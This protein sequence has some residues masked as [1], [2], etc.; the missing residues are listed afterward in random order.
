MHQHDASVLVLLS[1]R[2][3]WWFKHETPKDTSLLDPVL[4]H[5][6]LSTAATDGLE[7]G[8]HS[9]VQE[10]GDVMYVPR[11]WYHGTSNEDDDEITVGIAWQEAIGT[12]SKAAKK[13]RKRVRKLLK[14]K[15]G[16]VTGT[17]W[18][19]LYDARLFLDELQEK[20]KLHR[21]ILETRKGKRLFETAER[22]AKKAKQIRVHDL[23]F[24]PNVLLAEMYAKSGRVQEGAREMLEAAM[25]LNAVNRTAVPPN[26][27]SGWLYYMGHILRNVDVLDRAVPLIE[28]LFAMSPKDTLMRTM[29]GLELGIMQWS[30]EHDEEAEAALRAIGPELR[31]V[32]R[33]SEPTVVAAVAGVATAV[34][35]VGEANIVDFL[36]PSFVNTGKELA[37]HLVPEFLRLKDLS[38]L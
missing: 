18:S 8:L 7:E 26:L 23:D 30:M 24:R 35:D 2:K 19:L 12:E 4:G 9:C 25:V 21:E 16:K 6:I 3:R 27:L 22:F 36:D 5:K 34:G 14:A 10:R 17:V 33:T 20:S 11:A 15:K 32:F 1:G 13:R 29:S 38:D 37:G 31:R 28:E